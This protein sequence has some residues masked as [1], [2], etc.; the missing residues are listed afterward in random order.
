MNV[1]KKTGNIM[2]LAGILVGITTCIP[3]QKVAVSDNNRE[4]VVSIIYPSL[5]ISTPP[6]ELIYPF[7]NFTKQK[8]YKTARKPVTIDFSR[9]DTKNVRTT[10][11]LLFSSGNMLIIDLKNLEEEE[12]AFP[13]PGGKVISPF[14]GRRRRHVGVDI[15]TCSNDTIRAAFEGIV[16]M[17]APYAAY[18]NVVVIRHYNALETVY[19]HNSKNLVKPGQLVRAG[20]P[21]ALTGRTGRATTEHLHFEVRI[22]GEPVNP[23]I[24][25][26]FSKQKLRKECYN[27]LRDKKGIQI[28]I[29]DPF[30]FQD[31][32]LSTY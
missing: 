7:P 1:I 27:C 11:P 15:K 5:T 8:L 21:I 16:R 3:Y 12:F 31:Q 29:V 32:Y 4:D 30:L 25:Y 19:S 2:F 17:S 23:A 9:F 13:L 26:D 24:F 6:A 10:D 18:G 20:Q 22:N 14:G 28:S